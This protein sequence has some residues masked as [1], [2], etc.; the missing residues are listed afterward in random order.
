MNAKQISVLRTVTKQRW[1]EWKTGKYIDGSLSFS[2]T[3]MG[4]SVLLSGSNADTIDWFEKY[5][6][7]HIV[8]GPRGGINRIRFA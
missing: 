3:E 6:F 8:V 1:I 2:V 5:F 4:D 7:I